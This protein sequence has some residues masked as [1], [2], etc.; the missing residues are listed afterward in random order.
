[1]TQMG[2]YCKAYYVRDLAAF[3]GWRPDLRSLR[4]ETRE[5]EGREVEVQR[6]ALAEDDV[7]FLQEDFGVTDGIF[8]DEHVVFADTGPEW[9]AFCTGVLGFAPAGDAEPESALDAE[10]AAA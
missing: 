10:T 5:E 1:M 6:A 8:L 3:P 9:R 2:S 7:L 4:A